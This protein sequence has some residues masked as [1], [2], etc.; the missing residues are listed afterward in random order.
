MHPVEISIDL[1][2][3]E[4]LAPFEP[5]DTIEVENICEVDPSLRLPGAAANEAAPAPS[6]SDESVEI[7]LT[8]E[9]IDAC[10]EG[11]MKL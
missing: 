2:A 11:A 5:P 7:E 9:Q 8:A 6:A 10:L 4:L 3:Q 1:T